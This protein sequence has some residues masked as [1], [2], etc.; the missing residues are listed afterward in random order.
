MGETARLLDQY[1]RTGRVFTA[2]GIRSF[3]LDE[4]PPDAPPVVCVHGVPA[5]AYLYRKVVPALARHGLRGIAVDLPGLGLAER[6]DD[7]DYRWSGLGRWLRSAIDTLELE[8]FH[9]VVHDIGGPVGFEVA[10]A[11][12]DRVLSMTVLNTIIA[13]ET[14]HRPWPME[15]FAHRGLGEAWLQSMRIPGAFEA[16]MRMVGVSRGVPIAEISCWKPLLFG[17]DDGRA[18]LKIMR[19]F[20]LT[21]ESQ[22]RYVAAV[23]DTPYPV[24]IVWGERDRMLSWRRHGMQAQAASGTEQV[25][26]L[27]AKHFVQEDCPHEVAAAVH[28]F[29]EQQRR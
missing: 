10:H 22:R 1:R 4:G 27:P 29:I 14:F 9:L 28:R 23:H 26:L 19:G 8:R 6:P 18:F 11:V 20:E 17:D 16:I 13:V 15:P 7:A 25:T 12:P 24:Q 3:V 2:G 5:S 21:A